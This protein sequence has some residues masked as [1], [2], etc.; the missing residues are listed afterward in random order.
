MLFTKSDAA[1]MIWH[2]TPTLKI[3]I[4][5]MSLDLDDQA[6]C[7]GSTLVQFCSCRHPGETTETYRVPTVN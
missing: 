3:P 7:L 4:Y 5:K 1:A 6:N 2:L